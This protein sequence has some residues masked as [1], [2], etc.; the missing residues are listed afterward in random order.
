MAKLCPKVTNVVGK[1]LDM[2]H[3]A[4][5]INNPRFMEIE[6][7]KDYVDVKVLIAFLGMF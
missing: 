7:L 6:A 4:V 5:V 1:P 3:F 2:L